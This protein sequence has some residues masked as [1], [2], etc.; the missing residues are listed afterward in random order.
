LSRGFYIFKIDPKMA[1]KR[2][3]QS[4]VAEETTRILFLTYGL[5]AVQMAEHRC[6]ELIKAGDK[7]RLATW[8][9]VLETP[10]IGSYK[11]EALRQDWHAL[12]HTISHTPA[13]AGGPSVSRHPPLLP[14]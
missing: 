1:R 3:S 7:A 5:H 12:H 8:R 4:D 11:S 14:R 10:K 13:A 9:K 2:L 6:A